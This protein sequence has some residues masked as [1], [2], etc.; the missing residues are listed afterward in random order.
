MVVFALFFS[1]VYVKRS[2]TPSNSDLTDFYDVLNVLAQWLKIIVIEY[3][4]HFN[5]WEFNLPKALVRSVSFDSIEV[6]YF[7]DNDK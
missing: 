5:D 2:S 7:C 1:W 3:V 6:I 4:E